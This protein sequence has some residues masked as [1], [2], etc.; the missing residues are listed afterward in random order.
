M[1]AP[2]ASKAAATWN[3]TLLQLQNKETSVLVKS[4]TCTWPANSFWSVRMVPLGW[5]N[6]LWACPELQ[7]TH[8]GRCFWRSSSGPSSSCLVPHEPLIPCGIPHKGL[9]CVNSPPIAYLGGCLGPNGSKPSKHGYT[10]HTCNHTSPDIQRLGHC[11]LIG[12]R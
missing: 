6:S 7:Q 10:S 1:Q 3:K 2:D 9:F 8:M 12:R 4:M 11:V 5:M